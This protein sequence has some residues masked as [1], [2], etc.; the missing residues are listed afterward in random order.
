MKIEREFDGG[1]LQ[2]LAK[3]GAARLYI[4]ETKGAATPGA[5]ANDLKGKLDS[6]GLKG[7][8]RRLKKHSAYAILRV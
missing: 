8:V 6:L 3:T 5:A 2:I 4:L 7:E 1:L